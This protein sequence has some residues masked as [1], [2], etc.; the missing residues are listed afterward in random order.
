MVSAAITSDGPA[1][2]AAAA[3]RHANSAASSGGS[4][5]QVAAFSSKAERMTVTWR[6]KPSN[7]SRRR[8]DSEANATASRR[9]FI[10]LAAHLDEAWCVTQARITVRPVDDGTNAIEG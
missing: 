3:L 10:R 1:F 2:S 9:S 7:K 8:G 5:S 6:P 4:P